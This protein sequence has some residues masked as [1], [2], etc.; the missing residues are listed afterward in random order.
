LGDDIRREFPEAEIE[1]IPGGGGNF[2]VHR[3][4]DLLWHK[5]QMGDAFPEHA[6]ILEKL[7][8]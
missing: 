7:R 4:G 8:T 5:R 3:D 6:V 2:I 1:L